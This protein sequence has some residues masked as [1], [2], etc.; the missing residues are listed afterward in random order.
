MVL[1]QGV[2]LERARE[3]GRR[4]VEVASRDP[5]QL[6]HLRAW[7]FGVRVF[8]CFSVFCVLYCACILVLASRVLVAVPLALPF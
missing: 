4:H 7:C 3:I 1:L 5:A 6:F 2:G 8:W